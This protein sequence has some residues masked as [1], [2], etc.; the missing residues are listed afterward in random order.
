MRRHGT[1]QVEGEHPRP[2]EAAVRLVQ[3]EQFHGERFDLAKRMFATR[4][5]DHPEAVVPHAQSRRLRLRH[6]QGAAPLQ[7]GHGAVHAAAVPDEADPAPGRTGRA[8][9][10][11]IH[12]RHR[13]PTP[14]RASRSP[15]S[16]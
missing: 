13:D 8:R 7:L 10:I 2:V 16:A 4:P 5:L 11:G 14:L 9:E 6:D 12:C 1:G 15:R 3:F